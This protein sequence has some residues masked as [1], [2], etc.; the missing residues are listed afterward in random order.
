MANVHAVTDSKLGGIRSFLRS[1]GFT[2]LANFG[3]SLVRKFTSHSLTPA[4][5][6]EL[7]DLQ[8]ALVS[9]ADS[10]MTHLDALTLIIHKVHNGAV[11]HGESKESSIVGRWI[12][13][14][15]TPC[16]GEDECRLTRRYNPTRMLRLY[17][18]M[19]GESGTSQLAAYGLAS[20]VW[21]KL[22]TPFSRPMP[23]SRSYTTGLPAGAP[24]L[25][26]RSL[27]GDPEVPMGGRRRTQRRRRQ[28]RRS[29][30]NKRQSRRN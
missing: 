14:G 9:P 26:T 4:E 10:R 8:N 30:Q 17:R 25:P 28:S 6:A 7:A 2:G 24:M 19:G 15:D 21:Q 23:P 13:S 12:N 16:A 29:R 3:N 22:R 1:K 27:T 11:T 5:E 20:A 18:L